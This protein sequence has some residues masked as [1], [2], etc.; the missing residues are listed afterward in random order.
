MLLR[1]FKEKVRH[2]L[3]KS[4]IEW[5]YHLLFH[6]MKITDKRKGLMKTLLEFDGHDDRELTAENAFDLAII[7][8][9]YDIKEHAHLKPLYA[10]ILPELFPLALESVL[11]NIDADMLSELGNKDVFTI[12]DRSMQKTTNTKESRPIKCDDL[13]ES[14]EQIFHT[15]IYIT[16][17]NLHALIRRIGDQTP[18]ALETAL[19]NTFLKKTNMLGIGLNK[20]DEIPYSITL[21]G[22]KKKTTPLRTP[23]NTIK[24]L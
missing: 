3:T 21:E 14:F 4:Y 8:Y 19:F 23:L 17:M 10:D 22:I 2:H 18:G 13:L 16:C 15:N 11:E 1:I 20:L 9:R 6:D 12:L 24:I 7:F 5:A